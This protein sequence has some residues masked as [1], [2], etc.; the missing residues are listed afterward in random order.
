M[1]LLRAA[2]GRLGI[3]LIA[4]A[5]GLGCA[6]APETFGTSARFSPAF[7]GYVMAPNDGSDD[8]P[9]GET[10]L[11]LRDPLT[12]AKIRCQED[13]AAWR[14]LHEDVATDHVQDENAAVATIVTTSAIFGPL[15]AMQPVGALLLAESMITADMMFGEL[16]S[17]DATELLAQGIVLQRRKRWAQ[18]ATVIERALAKDPAVGLFDKAY[19]YLGVAYRE[20]ERTDR[21]KLAFEIFVERSA[22]RDVDAYREAERS[23]VDLGAL[24][25]PCENAEPVALHW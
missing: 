14:E 21:A 6:T 9:A 5:P 4:L 17:D 13:A 23:L 10:V 8:P 1:S 12:G 7:Q 16:N 22:V 3:C 15:V 25:T 11:L 18:S 19:F 24:F 20:L 2:S